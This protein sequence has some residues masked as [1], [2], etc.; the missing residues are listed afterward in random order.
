MHVFN[1]GWV[2]VWTPSHT[3]TQSHTMCGEWGRGAFWLISS[4]IL[5]QLFMLSS[6]ILLKGKNIFTITFV[7]QGHK[8]IGHRHPLLDPWL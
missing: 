3:H 2:S 6:S 4:L 1:E 5:F 7:L 8:G